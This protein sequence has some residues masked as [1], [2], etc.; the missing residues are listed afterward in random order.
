[1]GSKCDIFE[2]LEELV[3]ASHWKNRI[4][5]FFRDIKLGIMNLITWFPVIWGDRNWD[6]TY[7]YRILQKKLDVLQEY[8]ENPENV[9]MVDE[10]RKHI[11]RYVTIAKTLIDRL[12][13]DDFYTAEEQAKL[14]T[15]KFEWLDTDDSR[16]VEM[17]RTAGIS[18]EESSAI[19]EAVRIRQTKN[20]KL[21]FSVLEKRI[22]RWWD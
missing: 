16:Y 4:R 1:M 7:T 13:T 14:D 11:L 9:H 18:L 19:F 21:F 8:F 6:Q 17:K 15:I 20:R 22:E 2:E 5:I 12:I 10:S 3:D